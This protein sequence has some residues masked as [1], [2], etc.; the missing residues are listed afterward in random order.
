MPDNRNRRMAITR[1]LAE[2]CETIADFDNKILSALT[3]DVE[4]E[5]GVLIGG[6]YPTHVQESLVVLSEAIKNYLWL[7]ERTPEA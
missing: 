1:L 3:D 5:Q 4:I 7:K 6:D 2:G